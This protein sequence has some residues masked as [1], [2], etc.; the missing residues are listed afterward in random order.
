MPINKI[1][2]CGWINLN[3][4]TRFIILKPII[5]EQLASSESEDDEI[6]RRKSKKTKG[7]VL[8]SPEVS[9]SVITVA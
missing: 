2:N 5:D 8:E 4:L 6:F 9:H 3:L 7:N 1:D